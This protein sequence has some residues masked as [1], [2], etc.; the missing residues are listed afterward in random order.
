MNIETE[1]HNL[2]H[3]LILKILSPEHP[4]SVDSVLLRRCLADF[5]YPL[6][7]K[8]LKSYLAYL[9]ERGCIRMDEKKDYGIIMATI[10]AKGLDIL[11]GRI[12]EP[13]IKLD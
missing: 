3:V 10:T 7:E 9:H 4:K 12:T 6:S 2:I 1:K 8:A 11:D 5:G 13:G